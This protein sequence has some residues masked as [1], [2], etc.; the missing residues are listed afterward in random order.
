MWVAECPHCQ[1]RRLYSARRVRAVH[2]LAAGIILVELSCYCGRPVRLLTGR[3][4][5]GPGARLPA[6][7]P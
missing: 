3:R 2:N 1:R 4:L 7:C 5:T 6:G